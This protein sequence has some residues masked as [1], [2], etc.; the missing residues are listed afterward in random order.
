MSFDL[1]RPGKNAVKITPF[2]LVPPF[3]PPPPLTTVPTN[4]QGLFSLKDKP[5]APNSHA[6]SLCLGTLQGQGE[7]KPHPADNCASLPLRTQAA[8]WAEPRKEHEPRAIL[9]SPGPRSLSRVRRRGGRAAASP[10]TFP[11]HSIFSLNSFKLKEP[12]SVCM[13]KRKGPGEIAISLANV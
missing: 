3:S 13:A 1:I 6:F 2:P 12:R 9:S 11:R 7:N 8:F 4:L 10:P 5:M